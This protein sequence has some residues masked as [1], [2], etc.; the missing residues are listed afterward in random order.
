MNQHLG[1]WT[2]NID[3]GYRHKNIEKNIENTDALETAQVHI[4]E[5]MDF[6]PP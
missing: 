1:G 3:S 2:T 6:S 5:T 4:I